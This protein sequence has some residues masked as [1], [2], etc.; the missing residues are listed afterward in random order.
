MDDNVSYSI[1]DDDDSS[2]G[3]LFYR[4]CLCG[5]VVSKWDISETKGCPKCAH[6]KLRPS[7]LSLSEKIVQIFKHPKVWGW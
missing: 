5:G 7:N 4:C 2:S 1:P 3:A 6:R